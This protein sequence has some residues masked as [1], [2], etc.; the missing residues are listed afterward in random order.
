MEN[1]S[2]PS[3]DAAGLWSLI[4][5]HETVSPAGLPHRL[6]VMWPEGLVSHRALF[7]FF[8]QWLQRQHS[9]KDARLQARV[10]SGHVVSVVLG[11]FSSLEIASQLTAGLENPRLGV[12]GT[13][14]YISFT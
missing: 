10:C 13:F 14:V 3:S 6:A 9:R 11:T 7:L 12:V 2:S 8:T 4:R 5:Q 1:P